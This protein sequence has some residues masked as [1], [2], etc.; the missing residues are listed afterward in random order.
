MA[1][2]ENPYFARSFVNRVWGHYLGVGIVHPVDDFSL[3]NPPS[4]PTLLDALA[5]D[6]IES[7]FDIRAIEKRVLMSRTYQLSS[8][9]NETNRLDRNNFARAYVRP[10]MAEVVVDVLNAAL[11]VSE[12]W[13]PAEGTPGG[14]AIEVGASRV[15]NAAVAHAFRVF[16]RPPRTS[17]CDCERA[18]DPALPQKLY[19][20]ADQ[21]LLAKLKAPQNRLTRLLKDHADDDK[22]LGEL[23][24]ATLSRMPT[25]RDRAVFA[26]HKEKKGPKANRRDVFTD[27]LWALVNTSEFIFNH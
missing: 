23:F 27:V 7:G 17:A 25:E 13:S 20:M 5:K 10:L 14:R 12:K 3:A 2:K 1:S 4:N 6:F 15:S 9:P 8:I 16:G 19:L 18:A 11:G 21:S 24:L 26:A 22:A